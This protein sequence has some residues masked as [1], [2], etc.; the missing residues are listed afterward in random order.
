MDKKLEETG[1]G[2]PPADEINREGM[3]WFVVHTLTGQEMR[4][5]RFIDT[6]KISAELFDRIGH[7]FT[8]MEKVVKVIKSSDPT[9][10]DK[11]RTVIAPLFLG[12][13]L[14]QA[15]V[16]NIPDPAKP[17]KKTLN[18]GVWRFIKD[19]PGVIGFLGGDKPN[20]LS[21]R[22]IADILSQ[23][24]GEG[25]KA[26]PEI[27][28]RI[29]EVVR[30]P[31]GAFKGSQGPIDKVDPDKGKLSVTV[32]VFGRETPVELEYNQVERQTADATPALG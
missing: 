3:Q 9:K 21:E 28:Y 5:N 14:V 30:I 32:S 1:L 25:A 8:P 23:A 15:Q 24:G 16:W 4:A 26:R 12:Y 6:Q 7:V 2:L 27:D 31:E 11:K 10:K 13:L 18:I 17:R 20:P 19:T 29:G 22:E